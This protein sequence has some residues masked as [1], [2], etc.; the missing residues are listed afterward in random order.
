MKKTGNVL[1]IQ[2]VL[3]AEKKPSKK[4]SVIRQK[5]WKYLE[6]AGVMDSLDRQFGKTPRMTGRWTTRY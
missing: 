1:K 2:G 5:V 3:L 6:G 4:C